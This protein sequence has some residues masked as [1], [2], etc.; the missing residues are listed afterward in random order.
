MEGDAKDAE[1]YG[2]PVG[3]I[4]M[5]AAPSQ[6]TSSGMGWV[7]A[8]VI[9]AALAIFWMSGLGDPS[10]QT[11]ATPAQTGISAAEE[12]ALRF[13][14]SS[15]PQSIAEAAG[16]NAQI[17]E[18]GDGLI[19]TVQ[20]PPQP[21][22]ADYIETVA[23]L[24]QRTAQAVQAGASDLPRSAV[25]ISYVTLRPEPGGAQAYSFLALD[26]PVEALRRADI[27]ALGP[28]GILNLAERPQIVLPHQ[29]PLAGW[30]RGQPAA[31]DFCARAKA[32]TGRGYWP[33]P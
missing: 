28:V 18:V 26:L 5:S 14:R 21:T 22:E 24:A 29:V 11:N 20:L 17:G 16:P 33:D 2:P 7:I 31:V 13:D 23:A 25:A 6:T 27:G 12:N 3:P 32:R 10:A 1:Q 9:L 19:I 4:G 15:E 30:C 8:A